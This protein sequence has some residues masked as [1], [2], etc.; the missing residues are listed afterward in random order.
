M[1]PAE[2]HGIQSVQ[3]RDTQTARAGGR[4]CQAASSA[5]L[6]E[7]DSLRE[8]ALQKIQLHNT[9]LMFTMT[10][11]IAVFV[12]AFTTKVPEMFLLPLV[13][14]VPATWKAACYRTTRWA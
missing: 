1:R 12:L 7:Y 5:L 9:T 10:S 11:G 6:A 4:A 13:V 2:P 3:I 8:E 14:V